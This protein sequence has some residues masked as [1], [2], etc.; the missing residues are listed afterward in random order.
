MKPSVWGDGQFGCQL[1][2]MHADP[3]PFPIGTKTD[4]LGAAAMTDG[5]QER[6]IP[7]GRAELWRQGLSGDAAGQP[8]RNA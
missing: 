7:R 5:L 8:A 1:F 2:A 6:A 4:L 3:H